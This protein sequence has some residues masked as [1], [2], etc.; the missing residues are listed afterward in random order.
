MTDMF[1]AIAYWMLSSTALWFIGKMFIGYFGLGDRQYQV[2]MPQANLEILLTHVLH[3]ATLRTPSQVGTWFATFV[4]ATYKGES[5]KVILQVINDMQAMPEAAEGPME[6]QSGYDAET[7][8]MCVRFMERYPN[9][10]VSLPVGFDMSC[11]ASWEDWRQ[12]F[13]GGVDGFK[14]VRFAPLYKHIRR[15]IAACI[16]GTFLSDKM[17]TDYKW[18]HKRLFDGVDAKNGLD[19]IDIFDELLDL[20][21][22]VFDTA[23]YCVQ[24]QSLRPL[25]GRGKESVAL[26]TEHA[27]LTA[28][29]EYFLLGSL[30]S[31]T[32][33]GGKICTSET[34]VGRVERHLAAIKR[35]HAGSRD[36]ERVVLA[37]CLTQAMRWDVEVKD[38]FSRSSLRME[39]LGIL[40]FGPTAQGKT[41]KGMQIMA[42]VLQGCGFPHTEQ[43]VSQ[44]DPNSKYMDTISNATMGV[45]MDDVANT[46]AEFAK[47]DAL[48]LFIQIQNT[49]NVPVSKA[50]LEEKG[51]VF[52]NSKVIIVSTNTKDLNAN[53]TSNEPSAI[54]RRFG[55]ALRVRVKPEYAYTMDESTTVGLEGRPTLPMIDPSK[56]TDGI[57]TPAQLFDVVKWAPFAR[58]TARPADIGDWFVVRHNGREMKDLEYDEMMLYLQERARA[59]FGNQRRMLSAFKDDNVLPLC[60][61]G[62]VPAPHCS[63]CRLLPLELQAG[64]ALTEF[65]CP[66]VPIVDEPAASAR[67]APADAVPAAT[68]PPPEQTVTWWERTSIR[69]RVWWHCATVAQQPPDVPRVLGWIKAM[70]HGAF[71]LEQ[72]AFTHFDAVMLVLLSVAPCVATVSSSFLALVGCGWFVTWT[73]WF[74]VFAFTG[75]SL[76]RNARG[77]VAARVAG[78]TL[79]EL[80]R[81]SLDM[82]KASFGILAAFIG[83]LVFVQGAR[84][85]TAYACD[86][87][88]ESRAAP[89]SEEPRVVAPG[90]RLP[91]Q[92]DPTPLLVQGGAISTCP[93]PDAVADP[94]FKKNVWEGRDVDVWYRT[95]GSVRNMTEDQI[96]KKAEKQMYV[97]TI[98]YANGATVASNCIIPAT[99]YMVAPV[100]NFVRPDGSWSQ[101]TDVKLQ[102]TTENR[103]P[104]FHTK[105]SPRQMYRL[106]GDA[107]LVQINAGG[108]MPDVLDLF[109]EQHPKGPFPAIELY[110]SAEDCTLKRQS[111]MATPEVIMCQ[112][113]NMAY[114]GIAYLRDEATFKG[115]CGAAIVSAARYPVIV[116][117]HTMGKDN[118]GVGCCLLRSDIELGI[119]TLRN[120]AVLSGPVVVQ[121]STDPFVP[122]GME[123]AAVLGALSSRSVLREVIPGTEFKPLGTL[124]NYKQVRPTT[125]LDVSPLSRI[126][127]EVCGEIR[128]HE[129]PRTIGKAT[130]EVLKLHEMHGRRALNPE[131]MALAVEDQYQE[132]CAVVE[133][134]GFEKYFKV[135]TI[136]EATSGIADCHSVRAINRSTAA[137]WPYVGNKN[138]FVVDNPRPGLPD[139]FSLTP[140]VIADVERAMERMERLERC[141]FVFK[142]SHKDEAVSL[143]KMKTRVFEGSPLVLT[144]ITRMLFMPM[145][146]LFLLARLM[147]GSSVGIDA[148]SMEWDQLYRRLV[149]YNG[150]EA[151]I[152]DWV[153]FDTS[154]AYMEMMAVFGVW[155]RVYERYGAFTEQ[156]INAMW[157]VA[158]ETSRHF[159]LL[160]G[161]LGMAEG[162]TP[163]GGVITVYGNNGIGELRFKCGFYSLARERG[164]QEV[165]PLL[166]YTDQKFSTG[167]LPIVCNGRAGFEPLLPNLRGRFCDY[168]MATYYGDDF[169]QA[170]RAVILDWYNQQTLYEYFKEEGLHLTDANKQAFESAT[171]PWGEVTF[172]KRGFRYDED[173]RCYMAPLAIKSIYKSLHVWPVKLTWS[174]EMHGA[175][176]FGGALRE[177]LQH[178]RA[179][180]ESRAPMLLA[181]AERFGCTPYLQVADASYDAMIGIWF[182]RELGSN[183]S[184]LQAVTPSD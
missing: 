13:G 89:P 176:I 183:L 106:P 61:H 134:L 19:C 159:A 26:D 65:F 4:S 24:T 81:R 91:Q 68:A 56:M 9:G 149:A 154:Q 92:P 100:H 133:T 99:N 170:P 86:S 182:G 43:Y 126:V 121:N 36:A 47:T 130:V 76:S 162:T 83:V 178:G 52:H 167:G 39:P 27:Y 60:R 50:G 156:Q 37:R 66:E 34:Y 63:I 140:E 150:E 49:S 129:P 138:P 40:L 71:D 46:K 2:A 95:E 166:D 128:A 165:V 32:E 136:D 14:A 97:M 87:K 17:A 131:D 113:Y 84:K 175:Q 107:M 109:A 58:T 44:V 104:V 168:V 151:V 15:I 20:T 169:V 62:A 35:H 108:T 139:A 112:T 172:L 94:V 57:Y 177:L 158:E 102:C 30:E 85:L 141:N 161:D 181:A 96:Y 54:M 74:S 6:V 18:F 75:V 45:F 180:Y 78:A 16:A 123:D 53:L 117:F 120:Q 5:A 155:I 143:G 163:S 48:A 70:S 152:G 8:D 80:K 69:C 135:L 105:V 38:H 3:A 115:L 114:N 12:S 184:F 67:A 1:L 148:T 124:L 88:H 11:Q 41:T 164:Q 25:L 10:V 33:A 93:P 160:R 125:R 22:A 116:G 118:R 79:E 73:A 55:V 42:H 157:V 132:M 29:H 146:R 59:H 23:T 77:W 153:H 122:T 101:I 64:D 31:V 171:T 82:A 21:K 110:R 103:G 144:I 28:H 173:T 137:G 127:E 147:T 179:V 90:E 7:A 174:K 145:I 119:A 98:V 72:L 51:K 142:G 111:Y